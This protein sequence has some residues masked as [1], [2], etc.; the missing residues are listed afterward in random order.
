MR[1][2]NMQKILTKKTITIEIHNGLLEI[3]DIPEDV[4]IIVK[5]YDIEGTEKNKLSGD[6]YGHPCLI[7]EWS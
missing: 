5:D 7:Q 2:L 4:Q 1:V 3:Y 6:K